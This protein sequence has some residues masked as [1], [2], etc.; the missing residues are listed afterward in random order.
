MCIY[1]YI[2]KTQEIIFAVCMCINKYAGKKFNSGFFFK[3]I[4]I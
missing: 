1:I 3:K 4:V 2:Y